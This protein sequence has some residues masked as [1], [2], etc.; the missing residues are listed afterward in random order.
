MYQRLFPYIDKVIEEG[1]QQP[2]V[3][4]GNLFPGKVS[5]KA[6]KPREEDGKVEREVEIKIG[7]GNKVLRCRGIG[8]NGK[9]AKF[10]AAKCALREL[11]K[12]HKQKDNDNL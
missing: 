9:Q 5:Y 4:L 12:C 8:N 10:A 2:V 3:E 6:A 7:G 1:P 11:R